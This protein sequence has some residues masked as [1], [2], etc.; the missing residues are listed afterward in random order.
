MINNKLKTNWLEI[1]NFNSRLNIIE[2]P[3]TTEKLV[4]IPLTPIKIDAYLLNYLLGYLYSEL[5]NDQQ[6]ILDIILSDFDLPNKIQGL[7]LYKT[8]KPGIVESMKSLPKDFL[9]IKENDLTDIDSLFNKIQSKILEDFK[10]KISSFRIFM[11]R[12]ID[13]IN[14]LYENF[15]TL[16][17]YDFLKQFL[18]LIQK[19]IGQNLFLIYPEPLLT[20]FVKK[21]IDI[22]K[23]IKFSEIFEYIEDLIPEFSNNTIIN[24]KELLISFQVEKL[25][26]KSQSKIKFKIERVKHV[27]APLDYNNMDKIN[28]LITSKYKP[29]NIIYVEQK[30]LF[31]LLKDLFYL[32]IPLRKEELKLF[33]QKILYGIRSYNLHWKMFP[34]PKIYNILKRFL[35]RLIGININFKKLSHWAIPEFLFNLIDI[36]CGLNSN[37]LLILT[38]NNNSDK[39][40]GLYCKIEESSLIRIQPIKINKNLSLGNLKI[41]ISND[42]DLVSCVIKLDKT[43]LKQFLDLFIFNFHKFNFF[44]L[45]K[46]FK[47]FKNPK[48]FQIYPEL[49]PIHLLRNKSSLGLIKTLLPIFI[50]KHEF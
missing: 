44:K 36:Y 26:S 24:S 14:R 3:K 42:F 20:K 12:G 18:D 35:I 25:Y 1:I 50:D 4:T 15:D 5:I 23:D 13:L 39:V 38:D 29:E 6:N 28:K 19:L 9:K 10:L 49:P 37:I 41:Q 34:R 16:S 17:F 21:N 33:F 47:T 32:N 27:N 48:F 45:I 22:I 40:I 30:P 11:R 46:F 31:S 8:Q 43:V 7:Y 2:D